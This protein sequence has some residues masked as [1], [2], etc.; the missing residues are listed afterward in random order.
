MTKQLLAIAAVHIFALLYAADTAAQASRTRVSASEV[1]GTFRFNFTGKYRGSYSEIRILALGKGKL[2]VE[3]DLTYPFTDG[4]GQLSA[5][6]GHAAGI[7]AISGDTAV[8]RSTE[9]GEC[10]I[11]I[12]F[13]RTG[14]ISVDQEGSSACGFG[15]N[16]SASGK[17]VRVSSIKPKFDSQR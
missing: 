3:F 5:N 8:Y 15:H 7:A 13:V 9:N 10:V 2:K 1:N 12:K 16:V 6:I 11:T 17:Y 14:T 4:T